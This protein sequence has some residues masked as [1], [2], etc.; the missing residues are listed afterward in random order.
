MDDA[1]SNGV[2][3]FEGGTWTGTLTQTLSCADAGTSTD[4]ASQSMTFVSAASGFSYTDKT[5]C[6]LD[7]TV[8]GSTATLSNAPA[9]CSVS[10][11]AGSAGLQYTSATLATTD[12]HHMTGQAAGTV[13]EGGL[14]CTFTDT[15]SLTR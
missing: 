11:D 13:T 3:N 5:G 8:S 10:T 15:V 7:F 1:G 4:T 14:S 12:G 9:T 6:M 2:S